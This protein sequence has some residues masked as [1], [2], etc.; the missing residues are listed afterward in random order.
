M[1]YDCSR[2]LTFASYEHSRELGCV[3][4]RGLLGISPERVAH[5]TATAISARHGAGWVIAPFIYR[6]ACLAGRGEVTQDVRRVAESAI[7][8][9]ASLCESQLAAPY[10]PS[11]AE[12]V[13][14][15]R[16]YIDAHLA[17]DDLSPERI[18]AAHYISKRY[19]YKLF[20][21]EGTG[22]ARLVRE[23]RLERCRQKL[24]DPEYADEPVSWIAASCGLPSPSH[25]AQ[26]FRESYGSTPSQYRLDRL[27][28]STPARQDGV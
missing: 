27:P 17:D 12:L 13:L 10:V 3:V 5:L 16:R 18:A 23:H 24:T 7:D 2:P 14:R 9:I 19:L 11:R 28:G 6:L 21:A 8:L 25:F 1:I 26:L 4:P 20:E 15:I 22:V